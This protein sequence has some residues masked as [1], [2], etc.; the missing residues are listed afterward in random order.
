LYTATYRTPVE[1][2]PY[3]MLLVSVA[4]GVAILAVRTRLDRRAGRP[5]Q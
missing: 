1:V 3:I 2:D 5:D 4:A